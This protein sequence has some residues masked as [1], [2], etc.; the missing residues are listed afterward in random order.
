MAEGLGVASSVISVIEISAAIAISCLKYSRGVKAAQGDIT[1]LQSE[2]KNVNG[3]VIEVQNLLSSHSG[4]RLAVWA[5]IES[6]VSGCL[7]LLQ[8]LQKK[9]GSSHP[10]GRFGLRSLKWPFDKTE[11]DRLVGD[12]KMCR[13]TISLAL[14]VNQTSVYLVPVISGVR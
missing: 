7:N 11:V 5:E 6:A 3:V 2:V 8:K 1:R 9:L 10:L 4:S 13:E 12:L 14:Q